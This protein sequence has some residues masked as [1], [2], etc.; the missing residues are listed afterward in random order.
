MPPLGEIIDGRV[1]LKMIREVSMSDIIGREE[2]R[3]EEDEIRKYI[4]GKRVL[5]TGAGGSIG[6]ELVRQ[7][8]RF[9]PQAVALLDM[10]EYNLYQVERECRE[11][12]KKHDVA[13]YLVDIG[14]LLPT[15]RIFESFRPDVVFHAAAY[16]H[17]PMQELNPWETVFNNLLGMRNVIACSLDVGVDK[18]VMVSTD[19]AV[20]PTNVMGATKRVCELMAICANEHGKCKISNAAAGARQAAAN[21]AVSAAG[22]AVPAAGGGRRTRFISVRF[23]NVIGSSGS[24]IP[25]FQEQIARGGPVTVTHPDI[26]RFFMSIPE[27][28]QL[29]MQAGAMGNGREIYILKMGEPVR[30]VDLARDVIRFNGLEPDHDIEIV[31]TGLRPGE[32]LYEELITEGEGIVPTRHEKIMVL[33]SSNGVD[34][35]RLSHHLDDII[36]IADTF[37]APAIRAKLHEIVSDYTPTN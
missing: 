22:G 21:E 36:R 14:D 2:V 27:A 29:I 17:V 26:T 32:K 28:A 16:K 15:R 25:L 30:I 3:L 34:P 9:N 23:G 37:D 6:S 33:L 4:F 11:R 8:G 10:S 1:S 5:V 19:K 13:A 18:F 31:F 35:E 24:V 7:V 12:A 20:R